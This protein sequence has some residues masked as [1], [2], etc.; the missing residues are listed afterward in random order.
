[1]P[2]Q[3]DEYTRRAELP[4]MDI[5]AFNREFADWLARHAELKDAGRPAQLREW[6]R[7][8]D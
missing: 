2:Q 1:M 3:E 8:T 5:Q 4:L 6:I 7:A